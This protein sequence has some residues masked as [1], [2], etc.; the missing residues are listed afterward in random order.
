MWNRFKSWLDNTDDTLAKVNVFALI[1]ATDQLLY[2]PGLELVL[3][4]PGHFAWPVALTAPAFA[5]TPW[6]ARRYS[7]LARIWLPFIGIVDT[8]VAQ[9]ALG[10]D[11]G[12]WVFL[13]PSVTLSGFLIRRREWFAHVLLAALATSVFLFLPS[14]REVFSPDIAIAAARLN[15]GSAIILTGFI[16]WIFR[17]SAT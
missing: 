17:R 13:L 7:L 6:I 16:G 2:T 5:A 3:G 12:V 9:L 15:A 4:K 1:L 14:G 10:A 8:F 11:S